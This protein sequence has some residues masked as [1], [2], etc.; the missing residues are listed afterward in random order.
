MPA[1]LPSR[2]SG[3][4][5]KKRRSSN[6]LFLFSFLVPKLGVVRRTLDARKAAAA[7]MR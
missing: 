2:R 5:R 1:R 3:I 6:E 4:D 7:H